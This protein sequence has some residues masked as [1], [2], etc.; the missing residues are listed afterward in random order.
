MQL[1][2]N[3]TYIIIDAR[4]VSILD[5]SEFLES[6][7]TVLYNVDQTQTVVKYVGAAPSYQFQ[8]TTEGPYTLSELKAAQSYTEWPDGLYD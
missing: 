8:Y 6:R 1:G 5:F 7:D 3:R 4:E 2:D